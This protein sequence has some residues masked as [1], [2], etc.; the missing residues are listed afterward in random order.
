MKVSDI[1]TTSS[2]KETALK[3]PKKLTTAL[4]LNRDNLIVDLDGS[5]S[6]LARANGAESSLAEEKVLHQPLAKFIEDDNTRM[7]IAASLSL[8]RLKKQI[9]YRSY[10]CDSPTH[11][12]FMELELAPL[13]EGKVRMS[14]FL[15]RTEPFDEPV[16]F[17]AVDLSKNQSKAVKRCSLCNRIQP[18]GSNSWQEPEVFFKEKVDVMTIHTVCPECQNTIWQIRR[19]KS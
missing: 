1:P 9:L 15:L 6:G 8:C 2:T 11:K 10:R 19:P 4:V 18:V 3:Q 17:N 14:H 12:Q 7:Y 16:Q 5:W 13:E